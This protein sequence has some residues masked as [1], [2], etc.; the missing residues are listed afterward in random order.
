[1]STLAHT[2]AAWLATLALAPLLGSRPLPDKNELANACYF[3]YR[4]GYII[5]DSGLQPEEAEQKI[6]EGKCNQDFRLM[7]SDFQRRVVRH[8]SFG[9]R[10]PLEEAMWLLT[11][12]ENFQLRTLKECSAMQV[13]AYLL[14][15]ESKLHLQGAANDGPPADLVRLALQQAERVPVEIYAALARAWPL[16]LALER[17]QATAFA[18]KSRMRPR[19]DGG[20]EAILASVLVHIVVCRCDEELGWL[21]DVS[22]PGQREFFV[23]ETCAASPPLPRGSG[24]APASARRA[25]GPAARAPSGHCA[26]RA[27][28]A[29]A[30]EV[31][32][33]AAEAP[34]PAFVLF[35]STVAPPPGGDA[36][37]HL[38]ELVAQSIAQNSLDAAFVPL[39]MRRAA[40]VAPSAC[41]R[42]VWRAAFGEGWPRG[43]QEARFLVSGKRIRSRSPQY[44]KQLIGLLDGL[45]PWCRASGTHAPSTGTPGAST[46]ET[47]SGAWHALF[48]E[49]LLQPLR[50]DDPRLPLFLR[51]ADGPSGFHTTRMPQT[52][53]YLNAVGG[54]ST[55][56]AVAP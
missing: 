31:A 16:E 3:T 47:F 46:D 54:E 28:L 34:L 4:V 21:T 42:G 30:A 12:P 13:V 38:L 56:I 33:A 53:L 7:A 10:P 1:M 44:Y 45:P 5:C 27:V 17:Y 9:E 49:P 41:E 39:G 15:A 11:A 23:Y 50:A 19:G 14:I 43:Y 24:G 8:Y 52:S 48:G 51:A 55:E 18:V 20:I 22:W 2:A 40:P 35:L 6:R 29:H 36:E 32:A 25:A 26:A 37:S